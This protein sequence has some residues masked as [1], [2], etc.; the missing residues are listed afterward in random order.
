MLRKNSGVTLVALIITIILL[1][2]LASTATFT[3]ISAIED[4]RISRFRTEMEMMKLQLNSPTEL[5]KYKE[6][7]DDNLTPKQKG[8]LGEVQLSIK[9]HGIDI[10]LDIDGFKYFT[11]EQIKDISNI[12]I[13]RDIYINS[14]TKTIV[15]G[16]GVKYNGETYYM[17]EELPNSLYNVDNNVQN[18]GNIEFDLSSEKLNITISNIKYNAPYVNKG[19]IQYK[20]ASDTNWTTVVKDTTSKNFTFEV[21]SD[22]EYNI[23]VIDAKNNKSTNNIKIENTVI[24]GE[25]VTLTEENVKQY[26][27]K[28]VINFKEDDGNTETVEG[29]NVEVSK[30]YRLYYVDFENKYGDGKGTIYLKAECTSNNY[31]LQLDETSA[32]SPGIRIKQLNPGLY[33]DEEGNNKNPPDSTYENMQ[34][35]TWLLNEK[36]WESLKSSS[37]AKIPTEDIN[38]IVGA[39]SLEMMMDSYNT[40]YAD[41]LKGKE[42]PDFTDIT[43]GDRRKLFYKYNEGGYGYQVGPCAGN[44]TEYWNYTSYNSVWTDPNIDTMYYPGEYNY[45]WLASPSAYNSGGVMYVYYGYGGCVYTNAYNNN[46][47]FCPLVSLKSTAKLELK[48]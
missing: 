48:N 39:P 10:Q 32:D 22:G 45:Y 24:V 25:T 42:S 12:E 5:E 30:K 26:L 20:L 37:G 8:F 17:L 29:I 2:I 34:A 16:V 36:R 27:G 14:N 28:E 43:E 3:G 46:I 35:V 19:S 1:V 44:K 23:R 31:A 6:T 4:T 33:K 15:S 9:Q 40:K 13:S 11:K 47:A 21:P 41:E 7:E 38:Y 18:S